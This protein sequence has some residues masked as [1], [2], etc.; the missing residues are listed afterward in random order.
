MGESPGS[1][2]D[3]SVK[4]VKQES[5]NNQYNTA[6]LIQLKPNMTAPLYGDTTREKKVVNSSIKRSATSRC[7]VPDPGTPRDVV[8]V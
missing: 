4:T 3:I 2:G 7:R 8:G 1:V 6:Q 5:M